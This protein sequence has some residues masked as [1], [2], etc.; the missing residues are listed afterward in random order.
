ML[1]LMK[2]LRPVLVLAVGC[3]VVP[4]AAQSMLTPDHVDD[5]AIDPSNVAAVFRPHMEQFIVDGE[6][7]DVSFSLFVGGF[8]SPLDGEL[9]IYFGDPTVPTLSSVGTVAI[10]IRQAFLMAT[11]WEPE[12]TM[13]DEPELFY[14]DSAHSSTGFYN[15]RTGKI[16]FT[17]YLVDDD[18][19]LPVLMPLRFEGRL[20]AGMLSVSGNNGHIPDGSV[21]MNIEAR[22]VKPFADIRFSTEVG[23][24]PQDNPSGEP[25][26]DGDLISEHKC[27]MLRNRDLIANLGLMPIAFD[28][29]LDAVTL[30]AY[31]PIFFSTER[32]AWSETLGPIGHGDLLSI[33]GDIVRTNAEL[34]AAFIPGLGPIGDYGLDAVHVPTHLYPSVSSA[35]CGGILFSVEQ[36]FYSYALGRAVH[37]GDLLSER[38]CVVRTNQQLLA[39]F[40]PYYD[41]DISET[42]PD[43]GL[44]AVYMT[45]RGEVWFSVEE[46]FYSGV[47]GWINDGA[48]LSERGYIVRD[49]LE[50]LFEECAPLEDLG[51][52]GLDALDRIVP[53]LS[54]VSP[55]EITAEM[56]PGDPILV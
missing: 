56:S 44:D 21:E 20:R 42:C 39:Q 13:L 24:T 6:E 40:R 46:S 3:C 9:V 11:T 4:A 10:S 48:V 18:G 52:F 26:S 41:P 15:Y 37:H 51:N 45:R 50:L 8:T 14:L 38:G 2:V 23:F 32:G 7:S 53:L 35:D 33:T 5:S 29:G 31:R 17:L 55:A 22:R 27:I 19:N 25:A 30:T 34:I 1:L 54:A 47:Y 28:M 16:A 12:T 43:I 49:N 36:D